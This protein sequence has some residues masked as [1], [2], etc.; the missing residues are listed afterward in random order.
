ME[1]IGQEMNKLESVITH[2][3]AHCKTHGTKLTSKRK[4]VLSVLLKS[5]VALSAYELV[6][7]CKAQFGENIPAM[8]V[9]RILSFLESEG[10]V[11]RLNLAN[12]YVACSHISCDHAHGTPQFLICK[13][14]NAV[15]EVSI[16]QSIMDELAQTVQNADYQLISSQMELNCLCQSCA[17]TA[18]N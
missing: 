18:T 7:G 15:K 14:C 3:E 2:A 5:D 10:L 11:H 17:A 12:K 1:H 16:K 4:H 6:D 8:S 9:Y 13:Q